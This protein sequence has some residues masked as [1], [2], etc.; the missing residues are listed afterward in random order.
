MLR[1]VLILDTET[2]GL[3]PAVDPCIE[4]GCIL[5]SVEHATPITSYSTLLGADSNGAEA[6]NG[7][8][9][10]ALRGCPVSKEASWTNVLSMASFA[11]AIVAHRA[12]FDRA[13]V[14]TVLR[15]SKPWI[16][17]KFDLEW[18]KATRIG[19][20]L[21]P[22]ALAH[23]L[24]VSHAHRALTDCD[25]ISRLFTRVAEMGFFLEPFLERGL[26]PKGL[27]VALVSFEDKDLAKN[28]SFQ[29]EEST[30]RWMRTMAIEDAAKLPFRTVQVVS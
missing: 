18:P 6:I 25:L 19:E 3:N 16:C 1:N 12:E 22:L 29:W 14:P 8:P 20:S 7:I 9:L 5:Y 30:K 23:G 11:D 15:N 10:A 2:G 4:V 26:R 21:V 27:F 13:F 24:G 17:S 28:A